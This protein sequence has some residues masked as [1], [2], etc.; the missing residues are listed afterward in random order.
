[1]FRMKRKL[2][3]LK[4]LGEEV[5]VG[6][7]GAGKM[8]SGLI[9]QMMRIDG[10]KPSL[11][12]DEKA[13]KGFDV[14]AASGVD[15][16]DILITNDYRKAETILERGGFV[17]SED[18]QLGCK[19]ARISAMVDATGNPPFGA[20]MAY[21]AL[22]SQK[23][24]IMLNVECDAVIGPIL[25]KLALE[26]GVVYTGSAGD[27]PGAIL[28]LADFAYSLG[29]ELLAVGKGKNNPL[30]H[31]VTEDDL[32]EEAAAKDL[33]PKILTSF[34]DGTNTMI[35][36][37]SV[38]N[39]LGFLPDV[40]GCHGV[41]S[42]PD[43]I[44]DLFKLKSEGGI[45]NSYGIVDFAFGM[46]PGVFAIV[47]HEAEEVKD[48]MKYLSMGDGPNY[49]LHRPY[50]LTSLET[51]ITIYD[52]IIENEPTIA[53]VKGQV[54]DVVTRAKRDLKAGDPIEGMGG[55]DVYGTLTS[56]EIARENNYLPI[57]LI[58]KE[59]KILAD[60]KKGDL[61]TRDMVSLDDSSMLYRLRMKQEELGL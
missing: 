12:I 39:A 25:H 45:L 41:T 22:K 26:N 47:T 13:Q 56:Y 42:D 8:G 21:D 18:Y 19:L 32:K 33:Y 57:A 61:I 16:K 50:H 1:M 2:T 5:Q 48:L 24:V 31:Y 15:P 54:A 59:S 43:H 27:E 55:R 20:Q 4:E 9:H 6:L 35:E 11:I 38:A 23:H 36:L 60:V 37:N 58:G 51:P 52:A 7:V 3:R 44:A 40:M 34:V 49:C 17:V 14:L 28:E 53:P 29:F 30:N 10:M 46:A